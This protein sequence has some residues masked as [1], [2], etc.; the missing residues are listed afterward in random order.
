MSDKEK[1]VNTDL[2]V[3]EFP[4][5]INTNHVLPGKAD[6]LKDDAVT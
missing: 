2:W 3:L 1:K 5:V 4:E 6:D